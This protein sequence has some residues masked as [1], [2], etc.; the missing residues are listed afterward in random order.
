M[1]R[2]G[3]YDDRKQ[4]RRCHERMIRVSYSYILNKEVFSFDIIEQKLHQR[5]SLFARSSLDEKAK[6]KWG[7]VLV[8]DMM[9]SEESDG[10]TIFVKELPWRSATVNRFFQTLDEENLKTKSEQAKRQ[11]KHRVMSGTST[12]PKPSKNLP[13]WS[14]DHDLN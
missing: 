5:Q 3:L 8:S 12:R 13:P 11:T 9:S 4:I 7:K 6:E 1:K 10:E 14:I 2:R